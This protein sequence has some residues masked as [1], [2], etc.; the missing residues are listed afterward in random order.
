M[1]A[2]SREGIMDWHM[3]AMVALVVMGALTCMAQGFLL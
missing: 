3:A 1:P 2:S